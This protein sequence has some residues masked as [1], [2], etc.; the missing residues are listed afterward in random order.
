[1]IQA[2]AVSLIATCLRLAHEGRKTPTSGGER[3]P[4]G[5]RGRASDLVSLT[6]DEVAFLIEVVVKTGMDRDELL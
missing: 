6:I 5:Q 3:L 1:M 4:L 2:G